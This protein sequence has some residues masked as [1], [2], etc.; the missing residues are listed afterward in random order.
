[1]RGKIGRG[2]DQNP[3]KVSLS[4]KPAIE[5]GAMGVA[6]RFGIFVFAVSLA[7]GFIAGLG[8]KKAARSR[9]LSNYSEMRTL[10]SGLL[11]KSVNP[12]KLK[13]IWTESD[14]SEP[15]YLQTLSTL[16]KFM[17]RDPRLANASVVRLSK[18][19]VTYVVDPG[20]AG[21][22]ADGRAVLQAKVGDSIESPSQNLLHTLKTGKTNLDQVVLKEPGGDV[23]RS[24]AALIGSNGKP[25]AAVCLDVKNSPLAHELEDIEA[26][27]KTGLISAFGFSLLLGVISGMIV[28]RL[29]AAVSE[30]ST[31][32]GW[33]EE[34]LAATV[35]AAKALND[36]LVNTL[37]AAGCLIWQGNAKVQD[38]RLIW[39]AKLKHESPFA[40]IEH[41][42]SSGDAFDYLWETLRDPEDDHLWQRT[43]KDAIAKKA[44][45]VSTEYRICRENGE[46]Y[47]FSEQ[48]ILAYNPDGSISLEAFVNDISETRARG[49]EVR[50]LA[51]FDTVTGLINRTKIHEVIGI[52]LGES[53][54]MGVVGIE[55]S[56]FRNI[57]ESWGAEIGDKL[58]KA[59]GATLSDGVA[60]AGIVG[61]V[62][63]DDFVVIVPDPHAMSWIVGK[64]DELCQKAIYIDGVEI[65]KMCRIGYVQ[66][67][68]GETAT[69]ILRKV[70]LAL[71]NARKN[72][73][74]YPVIYKP[75][76][77]FRAKMRVELE[78]AMRQALTDGEFHLVFQPIYCN[79]TRRLVK[80]EALLR[81]NSSRFG[82]VSPATFIPIAEE[83]DIIN[84]LGNYVLDETAKAIRTVIDLTRDESFAISMNLSLRQL[85][86]TA[87]LN[88]FSTAVDRWGI[89]TKNLIIEVTES[90]IMHD[91]G[92]CLAMLV[93]LQDRGFSLAIDDFG[94]GYSSLATLASLPFDILKIDKRF[95]DGIA[96][97]RK[98]EEVIGTIIRLAR[99]LNLQI[100]AEGIETEPQFEFLAS[101]QVEYSQGFFFSKPL[102]LED[103][104]MLAQN[105]NDLAA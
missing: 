30:Q 82:Q 101:K 102:P 67:E 14:K 99:A 103:L 86:N 46:S 18:K 2:K 64:I 53:P 3:P 50:Q 47:W 26:A 39:A 23:L 11:A 35:E 37:N 9:I 16:R 1:M 55:I 74:I 100:V 58:L 25:V 17:A 36:S 95:V 76:M 24:Y 88:A 77:S 7:S 10:T 32:S 83:S 78:T 63:G 61:R 65:A 68:D 33:T 42:I 104:V 56:N 85:K 57:N 4:A 69:G 93:Q 71:E 62:A 34:N 20:P 59:F 60:A 29:R 6:I 79:R 43:V 66:A 87:T 91:A 48:L 70:N 89:T 49:E 52:L 72:Q 94:T 97:D 73:S 98:Q 45:S 40:W 13:T 5:R 80:A 31:K 27:F 28:R 12:Q 8:V 81:W 51:F 84:D 90:S 92:E 38:G 105:G 21:K 41:Q 54:R 75:E 44:E 22:R 96:V 19:K 15:A